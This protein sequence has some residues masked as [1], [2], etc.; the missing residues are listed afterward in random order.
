MSQIFIVATVR[1]E[2]LPFDIDG[3]FTHFEAD[4]K[5][6]VDRVELPEKVS[7]RRMKQ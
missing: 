4:S 2:E 7:E 6:P 5:I 1:P 3:F